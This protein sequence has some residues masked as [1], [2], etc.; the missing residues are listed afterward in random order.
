MF[1][2][3]RIINCQCMTNSCSY[4]GNEHSTLV[5]SNTVV[6]SRDCGLCEV[7]DILLGDHLNENSDSEMGGS[8]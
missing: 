8:V 3:S 5:G 6:Y 7:S 1:C 2:R 4:G